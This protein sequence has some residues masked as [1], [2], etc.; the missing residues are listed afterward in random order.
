MKS[1]QSA[2]TDSREKKGTYQLRGGKD[3]RSL[4]PSSKAG[5]WDHRRKTLLAKNERILL[6][7]E[8]NE[9]VG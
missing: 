4:H 5:S 9:D 2:G 7:R 1:N 6:E 3:E 8:E